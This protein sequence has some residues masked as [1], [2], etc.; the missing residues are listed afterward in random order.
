MLL[1]HVISP[2][3]GDFKVSAKVM[4]MKKGNVPGSAGFLIGIHDDEDPDVRA[5]CYFGGGIKAGV[6]ANGF[7]FLKNEKIELPEEF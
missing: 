3:T 6:S 2:E 7:A 4:L 1:T 5:A